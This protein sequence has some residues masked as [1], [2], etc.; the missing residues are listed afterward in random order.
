MKK[1]DIIKIL[2]D[3]NNEAKQKYKTEIKGIFGS[4]ARGEEVT[5]SDLDVLVECEEGADLFHFVGLAL[6]LEEQLNLPVDVVP[7]DTIREE[8]KE[9]ILQEAI[10]L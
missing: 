6:Y 10:Y 4:F 5:G 1:E 7:V 8:I 2:K 3:V 9:H